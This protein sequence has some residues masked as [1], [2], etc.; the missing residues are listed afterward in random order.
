MKKWRER[1]WWFD[2]IYP[3][4]LIAL[5]FGSLT[6][7]IYAGQPQM[8]LT[9][10]AERELLTLSLRLR[11][12]T[13]SATLPGAIAYIEAKSTD[14]IERILEETT[15]RTPKPVPIYVAWQ[16][17]SSDQL[18]RL[19]R[20]KEWR[21]VHVVNPNLLAE[22]PSSDLTVVAN[23]TCNDANTIQT[24]C[25]FDLE[26]ADWAVQRI[27]NDSAQ[28]T[29]NVPWISDMLASSFPSYIIKP[30]NPKVFGPNIAPEQVRAVII[31]HGTEPV[32]TV[33]GK[34]PYSMF[35]AQLADQ[36]F[37]GAMIAIPKRITIQTVTFALCLFVAGLLWWYG[38]A[39]A[40]GVFVMVIVLGPLMNA[41]ALSY[42]NLYVPLF[43]A[44]YFGLA[45]FLWAGFG[46]L[47]FYS[48]Q[49][50][51]LDEQRQAH[52]RSAD[53]KG[54]FVS[55][56][57]HNLNTPIAKMQGMLGILAAIPTADHWKQDIRHAESLV[58]QLELLVRSVLIG[59]ALEE[60]N[61]TATARSL[62]A[63][64]DELR[65]T[66]I[67]VLKRLG[68]E[69]ELDHYSAADDDLF[70]L[71]LVMDYRS[72]VAAIAAAVALFCDKFMDQKQHLETVLAVTGDHS[73]K[74][75][76]TSHSVWLPSQ[77]VTLLGQKAVSSVRSG[78]GPSF[79]IDVF[80]GLIRQALRV[81]AGTL[82]MSPQGQGGDLEMEFHQIS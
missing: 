69:I 47:S 33:Y 76:I 43:D 32:A 11:P 82:T 73:L 55:L 12:H 18:A 78:H 80:S 6:F 24:Q 17:T 8:R 42:V 44:F 35:L 28:P 19:R 64:V 5:L 22:R 26:F 3:I 15:A 1:L 75:R 67:P 23:D 59:T 7:I 29:A 54:N 61:Q 41:L 71:P 60:G 48:F 38:A 31:S 50:W 65:S 37:G 25:S 74:V 27:L 21:V 79:M 36:A 30:A 58:A 53:L 63:I 77:A 56:L 40:L 14:D 70:H 34:V 49:Q 4:A 39:I 81:H 52:S 13:D 72:I 51:R 16:P 9:S 68:A 62:Q 2:V 45:T 10:L 46:Q 57:S 66:A 20:F